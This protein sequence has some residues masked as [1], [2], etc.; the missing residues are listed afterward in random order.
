LAPATIFYVVTNFAVWA[1]QS[2]YEKTLAGLVECYWAGVPFYRWMLAGDVFY[3]VV[4]VACWSLAG[5]SLGK[6]Q[7]V[8]ERAD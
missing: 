8:L 6:L 3:L 7:P 1:F 4:L 5:A 2:D